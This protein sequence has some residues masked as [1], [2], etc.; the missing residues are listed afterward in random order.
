[1]RYL[2]V[3]IVLLMS[4]SKPAAE[5]TSPSLDSEVAEVASLSSDVTEAAA[6]VS[7]SADVTVILS[8]DATV[9]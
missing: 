1:M 7:P 5:S 3:C 9:D 4:C 6:D 2:L 8:E